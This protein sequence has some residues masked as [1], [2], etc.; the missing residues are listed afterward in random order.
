MGVTV[1][2]NSNRSAA[3]AAQTQAAIDAAGLGPARHGDTLFLAGDEV[4]LGHEVAGT[5]AELGDGVTGAT[6][7]Q[8]VLLQAGEEKAAL[9]FENALGLREL[10]GAVDGSNPVSFDP[11]IG[12]ADAP[13]FRIADQH[14]SIPGK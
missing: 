10:P 6:V 13:H 14:R 3:N 8:R 7:G 12:E 11:D 4:T 2:F 5:V 9:R 1:V